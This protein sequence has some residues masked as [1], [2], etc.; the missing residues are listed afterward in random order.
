[1]GMQFEH[2][3][4][5]V[6]CC[7]LHVV[8]HDALWEQSASLLTDSQNNADEHNKTGEFFAIIRHYACSILA[9]IQNIHVLTPENV[10]NDSLFVSIAF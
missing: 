10:Q 3:V 9:C 5:D 7:L 4:T 2:T 6:Y 8:N 1:M